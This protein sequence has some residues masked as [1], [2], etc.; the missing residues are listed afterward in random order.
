[1]RLA[2]NKEKRKAEPAVS[3]YPFLG[4]DALAVMAC[5]AFVG[6]QNQRA[7]AS[8]AN[9]PASCAAT[10]AVARRELCR[11]MYRKSS[12]RSCSLSRNATLL[13]SK[14]LVLF[15]QHGNDLIVLRLQ[16]RKNRRN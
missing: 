16:L 1:M 9:M 7:S 10:N 12:A 14:K 2:G 11:R 5:Y 15:S 6:F 3:A 13:F 8:A 4:A